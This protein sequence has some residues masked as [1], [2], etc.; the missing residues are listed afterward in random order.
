M[1]PFTVQAHPAVAH[2]NVSDKQFPLSQQ[3][4]FEDCYSSRKLCSN[5]ATICGF[6]MITQV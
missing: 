5:A 4:K 6:T 3:N 2:E 1:K